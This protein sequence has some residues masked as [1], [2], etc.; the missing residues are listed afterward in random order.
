MPFYFFV[1]FFCV[2]SV[3]K[4]KKSKVSSRDPSGSVG[5][6]S[7]CE[8]LASV[9]SQLNCRIKDRG[10]LEMLKKKS[11]PLFFFCHVSSNRHS[12]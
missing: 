1:F 9:I 8:K 10:T 2:F 7:H 4:K 6:Y 3:K 5:Q 12:G 11:I